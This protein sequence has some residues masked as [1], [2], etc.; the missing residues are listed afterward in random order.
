M[1]AGRGESKFRT[2]TH[3][4]FSDMH[5]KRADNEQNNEVVKKIEDKQKKQDRVPK[6][7]ELELLPPSKHP[8]VK[9]DEKEEEDVQETEH[10]HST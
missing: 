6:F 2:M 8:V 3:N 9:E 1:I 4:L 7:I 10:E 5:A